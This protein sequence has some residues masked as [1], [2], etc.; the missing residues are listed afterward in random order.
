M[1]SRKNLGFMIVAAIILTLLLATF[2]FETKNAEAGNFYANFRN[3]L[4]LTL[5]LLEVLSE[6]QEA[7]EYVLKENLE[8]IILSIEK[9]IEDD[10]LKPNIDTSSLLESKNTLMET[11]NINLVKNKARD[12]ELH[13]VYDAKHI[14]HAYAYSLY[15]FGTEPYYNGNEGL[16]EECYR[17]LIEKL[18]NR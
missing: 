10:T 3:D 16:I 11:Q 8:N 14:I 4:L 2:K 5:D 18:N 12:E 15:K 6:N 7:D 9:I 13:H 17:D 1:K